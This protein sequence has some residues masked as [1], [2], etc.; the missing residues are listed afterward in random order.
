[1]EMRQHAAMSELPTT[2]TDDPSVQGDLLPLP[3]GA[4]LSVVNEE[5]GAQQMGYERFVYATFLVGVAVVALLVAKLTSALWTSAWHYK[6]AIGEPREWL[7]YVFAIAVAVFAAFRVYARE[8]ARVFIEEVAE[9]LSLVHW[10]SKQDVGNATTVVI[11]TTLGAT[12]FFG[13][14]DQ[15]WRFVTDKMYGI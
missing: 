8:E 15:F 6:P 5:T 7:V 12:V 9:E 2:I 11:A 4:D 14:M 3:A 13:A 10:P 1:M